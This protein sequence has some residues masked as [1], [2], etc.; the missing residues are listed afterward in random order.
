MALIDLFSV[1]PKREYNQ[2]IELIQEKQNVR[3]KPDFGANPSA[4]FRALIEAETDRLLSL[5]GI[6]AT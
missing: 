1:L 2:I 3:V 4:Y 5:P 6:E